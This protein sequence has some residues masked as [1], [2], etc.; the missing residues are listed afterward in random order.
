MKGNNANII[1]ANTLKWIFSLAFPTVVYFLVDPEIHAKLP[2]FFAFTAWAITVWALEIVP[3]IP[4]AVTLTLLYVLGDVAPAKLVYAP[5][6]SFLPWL[7]FAA[8]VLG[9]A[10][11]ETGLAKRIALR[12]IMLVGASF[13]RTVIALMLTGIG[14]AFVLPDIMCR[15][16]LFV[17]I[18]HGLALALELDPKSRMSSALLMAGFFAGTAPGYSFL[19]GTEM[20]LIMRSISTPVLGAISWGE[21]AIANFPFG[22]L[23]C[24][25]SAA[26]CIYIIPGK[27]KLPDEDHLKGI[28]Q[29][30]LAEMGPMSMTEWKL[31]GLLIVAITGLLTEN[32]H[33]LTGTFVYSL[34]AMSVYLPVMGI[35]KPESVRGLNVGFILFI[36][37]CLGIG[38]VARFLAADKWLASLI[39]P[40][41]HDLP[42]SVSVLSAYLTS[43]SM[44]F[45]LTPLAAVSSMTAPMIEIANALGINPKPMLYAFLYGLDQYIFPYEYA[46]YLYVFTTGYI[47][48]RHMFKALAIR[49]V[50]TGIGIMA[51]QVPYWKMIGIL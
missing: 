42:T 47:T 33:G 3:A 20:S 18:A 9:N 4:A 35:S 15:V 13:K 31:L 6:S 1:S 39:L 49:I 19:T 14:M 46:L 27:E 43:V 44:N 34:L 38:A 48:A 25:L 37:T 32:I 26:I 40:L 5:W 8:L 36:V 28:V 45:L 50:L 21:F 12:L 29:S 2:L 22:M 51:L 23:Y 10:L 7:C 30:H 24:A 11:E 17:A 41:L 16:I